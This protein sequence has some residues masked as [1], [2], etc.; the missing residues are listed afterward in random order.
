[1]P[2]VIL[3]AGLSDLGTAEPLEQGVLK[4]APVIM[5]DGVS[6][7]S[8]DFAS[9]VY[10]ADPIDEQVW[11]ALNVLRQ[12]GAAVTTVGQRFQDIRKMTS[13]VAILIEQEARTALRLLVQNGDIKIE[14]IAVTKDELGNWAECVVDYINNRLPKPAKRTV[15]APLRPEVTSS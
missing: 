11:L 3:P 10:G 13:N 2:L 9:M 5:A 6:E 8:K 12:S 4:A 15:R 1:M 14:R 7:K